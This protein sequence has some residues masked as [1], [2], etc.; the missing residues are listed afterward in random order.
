MFPFLSER[1]QG[2][3]KVMGEVGHVRV[4]EDW[5]KISFQDRV[6]SC[7]RKKIS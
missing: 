5:G 2:Q 3:V 4:N 7:R 1:K 6:A